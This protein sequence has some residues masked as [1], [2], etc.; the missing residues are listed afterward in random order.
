MRM[1]QQMQNRIQKMQEELGETV[2]DGT[3]G[4]G[5]VTV[6]VSGL[7]EVLS[8]KIAPEAVDPD[9]LEMLEDMIIAA[10]ND[11]MQNAETL[12]SDKMSAITGG[13]KIPGLT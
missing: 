12:A 9:D 10:I 4:G 13:I 3:A 1:I 2:V 8:V 6:Q 7:K 11:A 5:M